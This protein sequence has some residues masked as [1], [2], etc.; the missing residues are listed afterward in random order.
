[1]EYSINAFSF[2][3]KNDIELTHLKD[4]FSYLRQFLATATPLKIMKNIFYFTLKAFFVLKIFKFL[5]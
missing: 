2:S 1:M 3:P 5:S 4:A